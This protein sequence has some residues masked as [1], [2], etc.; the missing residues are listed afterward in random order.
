VTAKSV[1]IHPAALAEG[2]AATDWYKERSKRAA[3]AFVDELAQTIQQ[4]LQHP[5]RFASS[6]YGIRRAVLRKFP[7]LVF[8]RETDLSV[9][10]VAIAHGRRRF[11]YWRD[12]LE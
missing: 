4:I 9:E 6:D 5:A 8:F 1:R 3:E 12:P 2:Q 11:G 7:F 10:V